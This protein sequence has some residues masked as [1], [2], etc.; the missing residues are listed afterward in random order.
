M[1]SFPPMILIVEQ[2]HYGSSYQL[3]IGRANSLRK[4]LW[5]DF[6]GDQRDR[7]WSDFVDKIAQSFD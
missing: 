7:G 5:L 2:T 6:L 1:D 4:Q 3:T